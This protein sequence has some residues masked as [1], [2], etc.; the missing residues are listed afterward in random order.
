MD[1]THTPVVD[2]DFSASEHLSSLDRKFASTPMIVPIRGHLDSINWLMRGDMHRAGLQTAG[3]GMSLVCNEF[4]VPTHGRARSVSSCTEHLKDYPQLLSLLGIL[5]TQTPIVAKFGKHGPFILRS[6]ELWLG[7]TVWPDYARNFPATAVRRQRAGWQGGGPPICVGVGCT[8]RDFATNIANVAV[9]MV[10]G[11]ASLPR[12]H[13]AFCT[14]Q[15][16]PD[17]MF[18]SGKVDRSPFPDGA[19]LKLKY[20]MISGSLLNGG[21]NFLGTPIMELIALVD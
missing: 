5:S 14:A 21:C 20:A 15:H 7:T 10:R 4:K 16:E 11:G 18:A 8:Q 1:A 9:A 13:L 17:E 2:T 3:S 6:K 19:I 12:S